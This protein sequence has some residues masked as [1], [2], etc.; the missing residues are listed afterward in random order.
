M[1]LFVTGTSS[2]IGRAFLRWC[3]SA[4]HRITGVDLA[5]PERTDCHQ[6]DIRSKEC[7]ELIPDGVDAVVH[8]AALSRDPDCRGKA[9]DCFQ[10]NV[11]STLQLMDAAAERG[12]GQFVFA[13]S[14]WVYTSYPEDSPATEDT[15]IDITAHRSEYALSKL[16]SEANLRQRHLQG[17]CNVAILRF[18][19]VY[20]PRPANW[21][22]VEGLLNQVATKKQISVGSKDTARCFIHVDDIAAG[23]GASL[24]KAGLHIL[25]LQGDRPVS[26]EE[27]VMTSAEL[28]GREVELNETAPGSPSIRRVSG[29]RAKEELGFAPQISFRDGLQ[30]VID[31]LGL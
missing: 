4:G 23:I 3:D 10:T 8:L 27:V 22:A 6:A 19:I 12:A 28:L 16:V 17:F 7:A 31:F 26:L 25:N 20:G 30:S 1:H 21:C 18:G 24:G 2:F 9:V 11:M 15:P 13:S 14:E 5:P 29:L